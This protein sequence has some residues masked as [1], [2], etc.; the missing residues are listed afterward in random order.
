MKLRRVCLPFVLLTLG[1]I[2]PAAYANH[3]H[4]VSDIKHGLGNSGGDNCC[5]EKLFPFDRY[6]S[7][8]PPNSFRLKVGLLFDKTT[9]CCV[10]FKKIG[11][12]VC[13]RCGSFGFEYDTAPSAECS[14][15]SIN[16]AAIAG[17]PG[18]NLV[19]SHRHR[20]HFYCGP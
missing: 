4:T 7:P 18:W 3:V 20:H 17:N 16:A 2:G 6:P 9:D 1:I 14:S 12:Y 13:R 10:N 8:N 19:R 11:P 5:N 15:K